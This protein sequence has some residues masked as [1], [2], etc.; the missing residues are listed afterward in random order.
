MSINKIIHRR[1][2]IGCIAALFAPLGLIKSG[3]QPVKTGSVTLT[4]GYSFVVV[5]LSDGPV[6]TIASDGTSLYFTSE[7]PEQCHLRYGEPESVFTQPIPLVLKGH[8]LE[9]F[10]FACQISYPRTTLEFYKITCH[11]KFSGDKAFES[12][13]I[14]SNLF[15]RAIP[16]KEWNTPPVDVKWDNAKG[17]WTNV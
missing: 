15:C 8:N 7:G 13:P 5:D 6:N 1:S 4:P 14:Y 11:E 9:A 10:V 2:F 16:I 12:L 17:V 3:F